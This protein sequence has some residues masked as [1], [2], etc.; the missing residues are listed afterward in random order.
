MVL[1]AEYT[2]SPTATFPSSVPSCR[3]LSSSEAGP[4]GPSGLSDGEL[5]RNLQDSVT[6]R[7]LY[8]SEQ[9]RVEKASQ[10]RNTVGFLKLV[11]TADRH[12]APHVWRA[13]E[14]VNQRASATVAQIERRL[15]RC[16]QQ[17]QGLALRA[18]SS[19]GDNCEQPSEKALFSEPP[20]P[21]AEDCPSTDLSDVIRHFSPESHSPALQQGRSSETKHGAQLQAL[22]W[23]KVKEEWIKVKTL[24]LSLQLSYQSLKGRYVTN[25][26]EE[27]CRGGQ[28]E[29]QVNEHL[30]GHLDKIYHLKQNLACTQERMAYLSYERAKETWEVM[31]TF[32]SRAAKLEALQQATQL[33]VTE[34]ARSRRRGFPRR[35]ASLLCTLAAVVLVPVPSARA[36]SVPP[37]N[38]RLRTGAAFLLVALG[39]LEWQKQR[40]VPAADRQAWLPSRW[41]LCSGDSKPLPE[42]P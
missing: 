33:E 7:I 39:A 12:Q 13:F 26:W 30:Q 37:L 38:S 1:K 6:H 20:K 15:H 40:A 35:R 3:S 27:K 16:H 9:L 42:G 36:C 18:E 8:L 2:K 11:S 31:D 34:S 19:P 28:L 32:R 4:S 22:L 24:H 21:G 17:L 10:D 5:A 25:L 41:R 14:E 29:G 23:Q